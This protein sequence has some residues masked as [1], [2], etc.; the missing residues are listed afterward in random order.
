MNDNRR[1][2]LDMLAAGQISAEQADRLIAALEKELLR[3]RFGPP[4]RLRV[5]AHL[6]DH[7]LERL[8]P[9]GLPLIGRADWN[10]CLNL[11][12]FSDEP[13]ESF[14]TAANREG[15]VAEPVFIAGLFVLAEREIPAKTNEIPEIAPMLRELNGRFPLAGW[16][17]SADALH[18]QRDFA[19]LAAGELLAQ[20]VLTVKCNQPG[21]Y[22]AL[23]HLTWAGARRHVT[24]DKGHGRRET[25]RHLVMD[26]P[27]SIKA[28]FPH[29]EQAARVIR[30]RTVTRWK[31]NGK[32]RAR[33]TETS[34]ET[35]Y[36][37][38]S[39]TA[40]EAGPEHIAAYIRGHWGIEVRHEVA[41]C[42]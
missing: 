17:I 28:L 24:A 35:V 18:T 3:R 15:G 36:V 22:D 11:N 14:Q 21:L 8:G 39:L 37:I 30:T 26:A 6:D 4:V 29:A 25:R 16:I 34:S 19:A 23:Q 32:K 12:C 41:L 13:G 31:N 5:E 40:R 10:D 9:H 7:T 27:G 33:V 2:I 20:Y 1:Q 38:T 42:E